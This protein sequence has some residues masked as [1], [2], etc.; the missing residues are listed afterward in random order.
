MIIQRLELKNF[1]NYKQLKLDFSP[2]CNIIFGQNAQGKTNILEAI[3]YLCF[4]RSFRTSKDQ[5][6]IQF[7]QEFAHI[8]G[9]FLLDI[10]T[11]Q[12]V[13]FHFSKKEGKSISI[14]QKRLS[15]YSEL[16]GKFPVVILS[17]E[18]YKITS[19]G[20]FERRHV[21][22]MFLSQVNPIYLKALQKYNRVLKQRNRILTEYRGR[23]S[24]NEK[25]LEPWNESLI[26]SGSYLIKFRQTFIAE[27][28]PVLHNIYN[29]LRFASES[30]NFSYRSSIPFI[31]EREIEARFLKTMNHKYLTERKRGLTIIG[32][33]RDDYVIE[34]DNKDLRVYGSRGQHKSALVAFKLAEFFYLQQKRNE[35][36]IL[37]LDDLFSDLDQQREERILE[38]IQDIGQIFI[39]TTRKV[40]NINS[41]L[42]LKEFLIENG[43]VL[44]S[45]VGRLNNDLQ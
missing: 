41:T 10:Q 3:F 14:E 34:I 37:L 28:N 1:R 4:S 17:P 11:K 25:L 43:S 13:T 18:D 2:A 6:V 33:H 32:P 38:M 21:V 15:R 27:F 8:H 35:I 39:T 40:G 20:P 45:F 7:N 12:E 36:P 42:N 9:W 19:G 30:I 22:D 23:T 5:E 44:N 26:E 16:I 29:K 24:F 31:D